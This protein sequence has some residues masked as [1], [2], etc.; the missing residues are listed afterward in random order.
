MTYYNKMLTTIDYWDDSYI[1]DMS[2]IDR[3]IPF[4]NNNLNTTHNSSFFT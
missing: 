4:K 2:I 1:I 3:H